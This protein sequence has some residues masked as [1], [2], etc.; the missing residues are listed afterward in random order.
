M[1]DSYEIHNENIKRTLKA[2][3]RAL[4]E[5][6]PTGWGFSLL[7]FDYT[8]E[9]GGSLFYISSAERADV[10]STMKEFLRKQGETS[11]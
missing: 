5:Y 1:S 11:L 10:I 3:G 9:P 8:K 6:L 7:L 4:K 2:M